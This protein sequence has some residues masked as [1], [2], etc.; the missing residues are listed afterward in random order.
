MRSYDGIGW[1]EIG[2]EDTRSREESGRQ[3]KEDLW[4]MVK[5]TTDGR[6]KKRQTGEM[7]EGR[8]DNCRERK[9]RR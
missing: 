9:I 5:M 2:R 1:E 8:E 4:R 6:E 7:R 3:R